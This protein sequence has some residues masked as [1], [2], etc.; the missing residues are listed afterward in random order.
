MIRALAAFLLSLITIS[1]DAQVVSNGTTAPGFVRLFSNGVSSGNGADIT[2]D[3]LSTCVY[4]IPANQLAN[5]GDT[6][7]IVAGGTFAG[8]TDVKTARVRLGGVTVA[9]FVGS[10]AGATAWFMQ[11]DV[12]KTAAGAQMTNTFS[13]ALNQTSFVLG[14]ATA[15]T[16]TAT[17]PLLVTGINATNS[18]AGSITCRYLTVDFVP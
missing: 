12:I 15:L 11:A 13:F 1:A 16:D 14:G 6:L 5:V 8:S 9:S 18:V 4:T 7:H 2:E 3:T 10:T 17:I